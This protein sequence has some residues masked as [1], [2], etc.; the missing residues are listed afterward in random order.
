M[1]KKRRK[2]TFPLEVVQAIFF[3][4]ANTKSRGLFLFRN[5]K[6]R[7]SEHL[8]KQEQL[9]GGLPKNLDPK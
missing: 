7:V 6:L 2:K 4:F 8:E 9:Q 3:N 5:I 1:S